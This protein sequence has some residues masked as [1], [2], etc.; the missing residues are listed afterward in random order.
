MPT[1]YERLLNL[2]D[3]LIQKNGFEGFSYADLAKEMGIR[4]AS[5]HHH[6]PTKTDLGIAYCGLKTKA[7][8]TLENQILT[9]PDGPQQL[10]AYISA[11]SGC[12]Q[13]GEMCGVYAMLSDSSLFAPEL[14]AAVRKLA[15]YELD[16]LGRIL[17]R[18]KD[19]GLLRFEISPETMAMI[20]CNAIKGALLLNRIGASDASEKNHKALLKMLTKK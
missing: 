3:S 16:I 9:L 6:F 7:F 10:D 17:M 2:A 18:G 14:K 20:V 1:T 12:A 5:I 15:D 13:R 19:A 8:T 4:K 11:F